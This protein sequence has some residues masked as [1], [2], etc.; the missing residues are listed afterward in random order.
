M[1]AGSSQTS[2]LK[3]PGE[4]IGAIRVCGR[5]NKAASPGARAAAST[6]T[7]L[8]SGYHSGTMSKKSRALASSAATSASVTGAQLIF[9]DD[10]SRALFH[11]YAAPENPGVPEGCFAMAGFF[12][13]ASS[14]LN[15][16]AGQWIV[17]PHN[18]R[19]AN[20]SGL[21]DAGR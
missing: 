4:P 18:Y 19:T 15:L 2:S 5:A 14:T 8:L 13:Q 7:D 6:R 21:V 17:Q 11:F 20:V 1:V 10:G 9:S 16:T 12:N 3:K